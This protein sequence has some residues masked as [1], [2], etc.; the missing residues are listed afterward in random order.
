MNSSLFRGALAVALGLATA[1]GALAQAMPAVGQQIALKELEAAREAL[2][3]TARR[4]FRLSLT[5]GMAAQAESSTPRKPVIGV[6]LTT[7]EEGVRIAGV[8]LDSAAAAAGLK[9]GDI[10]VGI[11]GQPLNEGNAALRTD[12]ARALLATL[13]TTK[14]VTLDYK[15]DGKAGSVSITPKLGERVL[16]VPGGMHFDG[17]VAVLANADGNAHKITA[18]NIHG[19]VVDALWTL[20]GANAPREA[21]VPS[22]PGKG[23]R[24]NVG[25]EVVRLIDTCKETACQLSPL[26]DALRWNG[27]NLASVD[28]RLGRYF[29]TD[30]GV[31]VLHIDR[32][33]LFEH[34]QP[35]DVI[36]RISD[37][38]VTSPRDVMEQ[39]RALAPGG[40]TTMDYLRDQK[41]ATATIEKSTRSGFTVETTPPDSK[42]RASSVTVFD[43]AQAK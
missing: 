15:R 8:T 30:S 2:E 33:E 29:G 10:L 36:L 37:K 43:D 42:S 1:S 27:L 38:P 9:S 25:A 16:A 32:G 18:D 26:V 22:L 14:P 19:G 12:R 11:D 35:G 17:N 3:E 40:K 5:H 6:I 31:L 34:L 13:D 7:A 20:Q 21:S 23:I 4:Y 39:L 41:P 24:V 28:A